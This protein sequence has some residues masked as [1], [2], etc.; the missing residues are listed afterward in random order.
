MRPSRKS[1]NWI[2]PS[3]DTASALCPKERTA[4]RLFDIAIP[5]SLSLTRANGELKDTVGILHEQVQLIDLVAAA[6]DQMSTMSDLAASELS[7]TCGEALAACNRLANVSRLA[8]ETHCSSLQSAVDMTSGMNRLMEKYTELSEAFSGLI[9]FA[10]SL[11]AMLDEA[12]P[13][14]TDR[15]K[16]RIADSLQGHLTAIDATMVDIQSRCQ[17]AHVNAIDLEQSVIAS[18]EHSGDMHACQKAVGMVVDRFGGAVQPLRQMATAS[19]GIKL[20]L[21]SS[22]RQ[23]GLAKQQ[24]AGL[25]GQ[26]AATL[27]MSDRL[28]QGLLCLGHYLPI[29]RFAALGIDMA[30]EVGLKLE[31]A[32]HAGLISLDDVFDELYQPITGMHSCLHQTASTGFMQNMISAAFRS[33]L[34]DA[35]EVTGAGLV[36]RNGFQP[37]FWQ[38]KVHSPSREAAHKNGLSDHQAGIILGDTARANAARSLQ[39]NLFLHERIPLTDTTYRDHYELFS[40]V[41]VDARHWGSLR[42]CFMVESNGH[43]SVW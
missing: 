33:M 22:G 11:R 37:V 38:P 19:N 26:F 30:S 7:I 9:E 18:A 35:T 15:L 20:N 3:H 16:Q 6:T 10:A 32:V 40:P 25:C 2:S 12:E 24:F 43:E 5:L 29:S 39:Q 4:Q 1:A 13:L 21:S 41:V 8:T 27:E 36:D 14:D 17:A 31:A 42:L 28:G 23:L 34:T